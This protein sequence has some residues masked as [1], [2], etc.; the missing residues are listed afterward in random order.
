MIF[1]ELG[2]V[3]VLVCSGRWVLL[4]RKHMAMV[5]AKGVKGAGFG[6]QVGQTCLEVGSNRGGVLA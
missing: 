5:K 3:D 4:S 6:W 1:G 2:G